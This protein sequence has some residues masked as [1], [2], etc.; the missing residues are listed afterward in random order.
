MIRV[1]TDEVNGFMAGSLEDRKLLQ[2]VD[3][4]KKN[5]DMSRG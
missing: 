5:R 2:Q 4:P 1:F 3:G